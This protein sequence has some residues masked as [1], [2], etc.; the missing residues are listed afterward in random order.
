[1]HCDVAI[2]GGGPGGTTTA[3]LLR[4]YAPHLSVT[5]VEKETFPR[6][7]IG[8]SLLPTVG[9]VLDEMG[10]WDAI[11]AAG[12]PIKIGATYKWGVTDDLWDFNLLDT[13]EIDLATP[14]PAKFEGWRVRSAFQVD[15]AVY[16]K[17]LLD[18]ARSMGVTVLEGTAVTGV[19]RDGDRI[20]ALLL[21][22]PAG[23]STRAERGGGGN[24]PSNLQPPSSN[25][26]P[27]SSNLDPPSSNLHPPSSNP[28]P[29]SSILQPRLEATFYVDSSGNS[30]ILR[31]A[32]EIPVD[33]PPTLKNIAIWDHWEDAEW[34][35]TI[36]GGGT[37]IQIM[38][39]GYGWIWFI[40]ISPTK[41]SIGLVCP[42]DYYK[43]S[44][45]RY[46]ELYD[47]AVHAEP[48]IAGLIANAKPAGNVKATKDWSFLAERMAGPNWFLVGECA[49]FADP[50]LSAGISLTAVGAKEC[51][52]TIL[53][54]DRGNP[55]A[56]W[57]KHVFEERQK[58]RVWQ[59]I[60]FANFWYTGN[61]HFTDLVGH[62][63]EIA[64]EAGYD[65]DPQSAWQWLGTGG[66][67]SLETPGAGLSG[68]SLEQLKNIQKIIFG[69]EAEWL[70]TRY[71]VFDLDL[72]GAE[73]RA[74]PVYHEGR[75]LKGKVY[76]RE[77]KELPITGGFRWAVDVLG[78]ERTLTGIIGHLRTTAQ[79]MGPVVALAG[80]EA[81]ETMLKEGWVKGSTQ[82]GQPLLRPQDI[83][84]TTNIDWNHDLTD[85]LVH[86]APASGRT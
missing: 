84:R 39:L 81:I 31:K 65:L 44:G 82:P 13:R 7:H 34:A 29:P 64:K 10:A 33:E 26:D 54:L 3:C 24:P 85:P 27:P 21:S 16:D 43:A 38:S 77:G 30:A 59:H 45:K 9:K 42:A 11:E 63:A 23:R 86:V 46:A 17:I 20:S 49:G 52:Y 48:M 55:E 12:F 60:R 67:V 74:G 66:F 6:D 15:R 8:E 5:L 58:Q 36:G 25:L 76:R 62:T 40:P 32:L 78:K 57:F 72:A 18:H 22:P 41:T 4:K 1:M 83:P 75:V 19:E 73:E 69:E 14:R 79:A 53:E 56:E 28:Q 68:H 37:R 51:A 2:V 61:K 50:I 35:V 70:I 71:N 47:E 80:L